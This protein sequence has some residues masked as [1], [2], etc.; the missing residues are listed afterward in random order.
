MGKWLKKFITVET[1]DMMVLSVFEL[2]NKSRQQFLFLLES[3]KNSLFCY[4]SFTR[5]GAWP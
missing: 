5:K 4:V 2:H 3:R 1:S